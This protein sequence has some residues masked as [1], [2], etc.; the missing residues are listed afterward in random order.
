MRLRVVQFIESGGPGGAEHVML[1]LASSLRERGHDLLV[2]P[3]YDGYVSERCRELKIPC[4]VLRSTRHL[5]VSLVRRLRRA[6]AD[7]VD[8]SSMHMD[9]MRESMRP[10][11]ASEGRRSSR[12]CTARCDSIAAIRFGCGPRE[13]SFAR[14]A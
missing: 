12:P 13:G 1:S 2:I 5:D 9:W 7:L 10:S 3:P 14:L 4:V 8:R 6:I 11:P